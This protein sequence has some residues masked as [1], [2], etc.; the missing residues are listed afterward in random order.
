MLTFPVDYGE[1]KVTASI[2]NTGEP[3]IV[4]FV[5][6]I[7]QVNVV[8]AGESV[9]SNR[10]RFPLG[11]NINFVQVLGPHSISIRTYERGVYNESMA[12]GTG[13]TAGACVSMMLSKIG[14]G[15]VSVKT[16]GGMLK[17]EMGSDGRATMTGPATMVFEGRLDLEI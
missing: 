2:A 6:N 14:P 9:N 12:C 16:R 15:P 11:V 17:I 13:A 8:A 5:K 10:E 3:H 1:G 4:V 7:D